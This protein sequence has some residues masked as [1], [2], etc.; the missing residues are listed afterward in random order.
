MCSTPSSL[1]RHWW[2]RN[3][4]RVL[5]QL[6]SV[7][8]RYSGGRDGLRDVS[9]SVEAGEFIFLTGHSGAGKSTLLKI[10]AVAERPTRGQVFVDGRNVGRLS[11]RKIPAY[12]RQI[13]MSSVTS[14]MNDS[15]GMTGIP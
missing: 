9:L 2:R 14:S 11:N 6:E 15:N 1:P 7:T 5:I 13:G 12:R 4:S 10:L 3:D 8:K